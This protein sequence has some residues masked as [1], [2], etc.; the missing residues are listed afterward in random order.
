[1]SKWLLECLSLKGLPHGGVF[2]S[3]SSHFLMVT[4]PFPA[5]GRRDFF[6]VN[7]ITIASVIAM[8]LLLKTNKQTGN[9]LWWGRR[10]V[11]VRRWRGKRAS[12]VVWEVRQS[13]SSCTV[14][15]LTQLLLFWKDQIKSGSGSFRAKEG[16]PQKDKGST[17]VLQFSSP[18]PCSLRARAEQII[19]VDSA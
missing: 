16:E 11:D 18:A 13:V 6:L 1:M 15:G 12:E 10:M 3:F 17:W 9:A 14:T 8:Y 5:A 4:I 7:N 19:H 2:P